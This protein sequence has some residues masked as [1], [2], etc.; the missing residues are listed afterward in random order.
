MT[1]NDVSEEDEEEE[2]DTMLNQHSHVQK[3]LVQY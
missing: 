3:S 2:D 1:V